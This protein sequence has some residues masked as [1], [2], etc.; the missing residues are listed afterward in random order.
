MKAVL[1]GLIL[2]CVHTGAAALDGRTSLQWSDPFDTTLSA[3][4]SV[5]DFAS[6]PELSAHSVL[7]LC[8][9]YTSRCV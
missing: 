8:L 9:L 2:L 5:P 7:V 3:P 4:Q 6:M 1:T